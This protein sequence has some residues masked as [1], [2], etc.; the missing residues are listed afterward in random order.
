MT[1]SVTPV[2]GNIL[3]LYIIAILSGIL[4]PFAIFY[5]FASHFKSLLLNKDES[6]TRI[7][8]LGDVISPAGSAKLAGKIIHLLSAKPNKI[9]LLTSDSPLN[10]DLAALE[11]AF[12]LNKK[13][14]KL[15]IVD[16]DFDVDPLDDTNLPAKHPGI[17]NF[18][19]ERTTE[20]TDIIE[21]TPYPAISRIGKGQKRQPYSS[22][23]AN[24]FV[25][26]SPDEDIIDT[27]LNSAK[28]GLLVDQLT[29]Q[30]DYI[31]LNTSSLNYPANVLP[32]IKWSGI[33]LVI[34]NTGL[35]SCGT[36]PILNKLVVKHCI[37]DIY[38]IKNH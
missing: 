24:G 5:T 9:I 33:T 8:F 14:D 38:T 37:K 19:T 36:H 30:F 1:V 17:T 13:K 4:L 31:I 25:P 10:K 20:L 35:T 6:F 21:P 3:G 23:K 12:H 34:T 28:L 27:V 7:R 32:L 15:V 26:Y 16:M 29:K 2:N 11:L 18:V 22:I